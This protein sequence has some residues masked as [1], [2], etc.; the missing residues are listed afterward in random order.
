MIR[1]IAA[2][3]FRTIELRSPLSVVDCVARL[4]EAIDPPSKLFGS[5]PV[6]GR[7]D[8]GGFRLCKRIHYRSS[9]Q[10]H[11]MAR[12][13]EDGAGTRVSCRFGVHPVILVFVA[14]WMSIV[15]VVGARGFVIA[16]GAVFSSR[17]EGAAPLALPLTGA[18]LP[19]AMLVF[20]AALFG[21][22]RWLARDEERFLTDFLG[23]TLGA[24]IVPA[25]S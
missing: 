22:G 12:F 7:V 18:M 4:R 1:R 24:K 17:P 21:F 5:R 3:A 23:V 8:S 11:A 16:L 20:G 19:A 6:V 13:R 25:E 10:T 2:I 14:A 9:F 15:L